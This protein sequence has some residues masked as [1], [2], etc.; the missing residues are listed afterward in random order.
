MPEIFG[1]TPE[2]NAPEMTQEQRELLGQMSDAFGI[3]LDQLEALAPEFMSAQGRMKEVDRI[4]LTQEQLDERADLQRQ[5]DES[6]GSMEDT[7]KLQAKL[8]AIVPEGTTYERMGYN[9]WLDQLDP[10]ERE[11]ELIKQESRSNLMRLVRGDEEAVPGIGN[12]ADTQRQEA[13]E[14]LLRQGIQP[15]STAYT[16]SMGQVENNIAMMIQNARGG[17]FNIAA[18][19]SSGVPAGVQPG[20]LNIAGMTLPFGGQAFG[21]ASNEQNMQFNAALTNAQMEAQAQS[22][23]W[24]AAGTAA[25]IGAGI[26]WSSLEFKEDIEDFSDEEGLDMIRKT[27][28]RRFKYKEG[29]DDEAEHI[30]MITEESPVELTTM[31]RK[32]IKLYD[33]IG[34]T[35]AAVRALD[36]KISRLEEL[37]MDGDE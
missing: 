20:A 32:A 31:G 15:G 2:V 9:E 28:I 36:A 18:G 6:T 25:G 19:G 1:S 34:T 21:A 35:I 14:A 11:N 22:S 27:P 26:V 7:Q 5:I 8:D 30:G 16:N 33:S 10:D 12:M 29:Y 3:G 4:E 37:E 17:E 13:H 23:M 24:G